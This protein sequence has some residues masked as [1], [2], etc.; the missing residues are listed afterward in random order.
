M[1][2]IEAAVLL[3]LEVARHGPGWRQSRVRQSCHGVR[4]TH[5]DR[6][7]RQ[8]RRS[9]QDLAIR[10]TGMRL[11]RVPDP[12]EPDSTDASGPSDARRAGL[13]GRPTNSTRPL[14]IWSDSDG[15]KHEACWVWLSGRYLARCHRLSAAMAVPVGREHGRLPMRAAAH[16]TRGRAAVWGD[17]II[18]NTGISTRG[19]A[20][21]R[22]GHS[23][24]APR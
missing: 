14:V 6:R 9:R 20:R 3:A 15:P 18:F 21:G 19:G 16:R 11:Q 5:G 2:V 7:A 13:C 8:Q 4:A 1:R 22:V 17:S 12:H 24:R 23:A 10:Q